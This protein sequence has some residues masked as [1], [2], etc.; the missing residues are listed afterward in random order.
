[1]QTLAELM[2]GAPNGQTAVALPE[3]GIRVSYESLRA[4]VE[5]LASI[6]TARGIGPGDRVAMALPNG[7]PAI[8]CFLA[9]SLVGTAAP[10]NPH[11]VEDEFRFYLEDTQAKVLVVS[12]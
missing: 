3:S 9:A 1:M 5:A 11:Y 8:V 7:L 12:S 10:L 4:Q 6:L 2:T